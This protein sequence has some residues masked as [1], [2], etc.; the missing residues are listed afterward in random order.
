MFEFGERAAARVSAMTR[1]LPYQGRVIE[2]ANYNDPVQSVAFHKSALDAI[3][4]ASRDAGVTLDFVAALKTL[5]DRQVVDGRG[6]LAF[7]RTFEELH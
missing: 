2:A 6:T 5:L 3:N 4:R 1:S 7:E